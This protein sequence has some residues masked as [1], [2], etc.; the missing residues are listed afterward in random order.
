MRLI[1]RQGLWWRWASCSCWDSASWRCARVPAAGAP[2]RRDR[3]DVVTIVAL[4]DSIT[5]GW[6]GPPARRGRRSSRPAAG[7]VSRGGVARGQ[8][9]RAGRNRA[10][11][12][13]PLRSECG[14]PRAGSGA[15]RFGLN[16]CNR[17]R[18]AL[19]AGS[20]R[21]CRPAGRSYVWRARK[22]ALQRLRRRLGWLCGGYAPEPTPAPFLRT[23]PGGF[24]AAL[25]ALVDRTR[26]FGASQSC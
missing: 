19:T 5:A 21:A 4:G 7:R 3:P 16:D 23:S 24:S 26:V 15:D 12:L 20:R 10:D 8:C 6:P 11:G 25:A 9:R 13:C 17:Y 2:R 18:H 14:R 22:R 1:R